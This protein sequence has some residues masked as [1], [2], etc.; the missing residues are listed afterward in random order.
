[1]IRCCDGYSTSCFS[2]PDIFVLTGSILPNLFQIK[3][4]NQFLLPFRQSVIKAVFQ[5]FPLRPE[6][7]LYIP[8]AVSGAFPKPEN[9]ITNFIA[10]NGSYLF[11][12]YVC[13][14]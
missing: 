1:M 11:I 4:A 3:A 9:Q 7:L 12:Y 2:D 8:F 6:T 5:Y 14:N 13:M 10:G